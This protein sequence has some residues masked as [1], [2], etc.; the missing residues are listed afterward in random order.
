M[1]P[2]ALTSRD[3]YRLFVF[4]TRSNSASHAKFILVL[5]QGLNESLYDYSSNARNFKLRL[6]L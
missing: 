2:A 4:D 1:N 3:V 6:A 5:E